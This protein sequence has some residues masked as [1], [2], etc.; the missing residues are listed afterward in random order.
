[1]R[2]KKV[3]GHARRQRQIARWV[4]AQ[5][6]LRTDLLATYNG[7]HASILIRPWSGISLTNSRIAEPRRCTKLLILKALFGICEAWQT[8][9]TQQGLDYVA[10]VWVYEPRFSKSEVVCIPRENLEKM[11]ENKSDFYPI[12]FNKIIEN[13]KKIEWYSL[14]DEEYYDNTDLGQADAY[15][16][17]HEFLRATR[18][19]DLMRRKSYRKQHLNSPIGEILDA[20]WVKR[21]KIWIASLG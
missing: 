8:Q 7:D 15:A 16:S 11:S 10:Q 4:A 17:M 3:R 21:G 18:W 20:F 13:H 1:M 2:I 19:F 6:R 5:C 14:P 9:I 12:Y